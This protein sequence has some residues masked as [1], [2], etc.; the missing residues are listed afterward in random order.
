MDGSFNPD[1][2]APHCCSQTTAIL[3]AFLPDRHIQDIESIGIGCVIRRLGT[4]LGDMSSVRMVIDSVQSI[5]KTEADKHHPHRRAYMML[6]WNYGRHMGFTTKPPYCVAYAAEYWDKDLSKMTPRKPLNH[7]YAMVS[8]KMMVRRLLSSPNWDPSERKRTKGGC[9]LILRGVQFGP[10][11]FPELVLPH[12][13]TGPLVDSAMGHDAPFWTVGSFQAVDP[14]FPSF[15]GDL[16][17]FTAKEVAQLKELGVLT[18]PPA[19]ERVPL[20]PP[21]V[22][23]SRGKVVSAMLGVPPPE[24][25][26]EGIEQSLI[27]DRDEES[28]LSDSYSDRHSSTADTS[29]MSGRHLG[30][31]SEQKPQSADHQDKDSHRSSDKDRNKNRDGECDKSRKGDIRHGSD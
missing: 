25:K 28:I 9:L 5:L 11:L 29:I 23:P 17:L 8:D 20:F 26:A 21:L 16:A 27:M 7:S 31:N 13:H 3:L 14:I 10:K 30:H 18:P 2:L 22:T 4:P 15:P 1:K 6:M 19:P 24:T 12:N